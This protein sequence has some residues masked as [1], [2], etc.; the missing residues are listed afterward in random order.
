MGSADV[1]R[2]AGYVDRSAA[3][4][5]DR[6][7]G[8]FMPA[9]HMAYFRSVNRADDAMLHP[10]RRSGTTIDQAE[11]SGRG[12]LACTDGQNATRSFR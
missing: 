9:S 12:P 2:N 7:L 5:F 3:V 1:F 6:P 8:N 11:H 4:H 10:R